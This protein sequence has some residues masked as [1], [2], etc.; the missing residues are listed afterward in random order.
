VTMSPAKC[1]GKDRDEA[2]VSKSCLQK[3]RCAIPTGKSYVCAYMRIRSQMCLR[4]HLSYR[5]A[6]TYEGKHV[7]FVLLSLA[8]FA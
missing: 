7:T 1:S 6:S 3:Q 2:F 4:V 8:Y 5:L